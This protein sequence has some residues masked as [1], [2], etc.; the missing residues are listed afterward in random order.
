MGGGF[1]YWW[2]PRT[3]APKLMVESWCRF[4]EGS[5]MRHAVT[6]DAIKLVAEGFV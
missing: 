5:G 2:N 4:V 6:A 3:K 1:T